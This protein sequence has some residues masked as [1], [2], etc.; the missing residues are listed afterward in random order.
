[1]EFKRFLW[2]SH[3]DMDSVELKTMIS[4]NDVEISIMMNRG[5]YFQKL[6]KIQ[7]KPYFGSIIFENPYDGRQNIY[8]GITHVEDNLNYY[9][10]D[11]RSP[12]CSL[13]YDYELGLLNM[14][15]QMVLSK[16]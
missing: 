14:K 15:L 6:Y 9:V 10:H 5:N 8:I 11:W 3:T 16:E 4:D 7:N 2:D 1:M 13:F 12:I